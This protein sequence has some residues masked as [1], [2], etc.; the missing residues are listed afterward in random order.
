M[1]KSKTFIATPPGAT[2]KE[3]L[4]ERNMTQT[5]FASMLGITQKHMSNLIHGKTALTQEMARKLELALGVPATF[6]MNLET[7]YQQK[8]IRAEEENARDKARG[9]GASMPIY[10]QHK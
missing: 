6:W 7:I 8:R 9:R 2:L 4:E 3:Q 5:E 10:F 1:I